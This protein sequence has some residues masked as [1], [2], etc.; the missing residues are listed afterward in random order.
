MPGNIHETE[1]RPILQSLESNEMVQSFYNISSLVDDFQIMEN[2]YFRLNNDLSFNP[3]LNAIINRIDDYVRN[4]SI[5][6]E[7]KIGLKLLYTAILSKICAIKQIKSRIPIVALPEYLEQVEKTVEKLYDD[8][9]IEVDASEDKYFLNKKIDLATQLIK[10]EIIP[11]IKNMSMIV[12]KRISTLLFEIINHRNLTNSDR[13]KISDKMKKLENS[14]KFHQ[15]L[16]ST[17]TMSSILVFYVKVGTAVAETVGGTTSVAE[18]LLNC[19]QSA[20]SSLTENKLFGFV[21]TLNSTIFQMQQTLKA[22]PALFL[23][24][25]EDFEH[26]LTNISDEWAFRIL[27]KTLE[28]KSKTI[29][30]ITSNAPIDP[31]DSDKMRADLKVVLAVNEPASN[32]DKKLWHDLRIVL[33]ISNI[34]PDLYEDI[35]NSTNKL[36]LVAF[37]NVLVKNRFLLWKEGQRKIFKI[38]VPAIRTIQSIVEIISKRLA[39]KTH[40]EF[41]TIWI[42]KGYV[43]SLLRNIKFVYRQMAEKTVLQHFVKQTTAKLDEGV[44]IL[45]DIFNR[46]DLFSDKAKFAAYFS[47]IPINNST[48]ANLKSI[49]TSSS[50]VKIIQTNRILEQYEILMNWFRQYKFPFGRI[51]NSLF[52]LP[53]TLK[54]HHSETLTQKVIDIISH[55]KREVGLPD[56]SV[57]QYDRDIFGNIDF[58]RSNR[59]LANPFFLW[60]N[61]EIQTEIERLMSGDEVTIKADITQGLRLNAIKFNEI[62]IQ[63]IVANESQQI[64]LNSALEKFHLRMIVIGNHYYRCGPRFYYISM[65]DDIVFDYSLQ[66]NTFGMPSQVNDV[67]RKISERGFLLSPFTLWRIKLMRDDSIQSNIG[68]DFNELNTFKNI[69]IDLKLVG[70]GQYVYNKNVVLYDICNGKLDE[71]YHFDRID[72][73]TNT[74]I[75]L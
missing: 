2:Q 36:Q 24:Q 1:F 67:Y 15:M 46:I 27:S 44:G 19:S 61:S 31:N 4:T 68:C 63:L 60:K 14:I 38:I 34:Q 75:L 62:E 66:R 71:I 28:L 55:L 39:N 64:A 65:D 32:K 54:Y 70:R 26:K 6:I 40:I 73:F 12:N 25:L 7:Q 13:D 17:G 21:D 56:I 29:K 16:D 53:K 72:T 33:S 59:S 57:T 51:R 58:S 3:F 48:I 35:R 41:E 37:S 30:I 45:I 69:S 18:P 43:Q 10:F 23:K 50:L 42:S 22:K 47:N 5:P 49:N 74:D 20:N 11:E 9:S 8:P 52:E